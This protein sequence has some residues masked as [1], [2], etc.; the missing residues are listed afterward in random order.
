MGS[1]NETCMIS[2]MPIE[3]GDKIKMIILE[4]NTCTDRGAS[5]CY[6]T[7]FW[8][9]ASVPISCEYNDYGDFS[10]HAPDSL[11][12]QVILETLRK[13]HYPVPEGANSYHDLAV[14]HLNEWKDLWQGLEKGRLAVQDIFK[15]YRETNPD[16]LK[17]KTEHALLCKVYIREDV[18]NS[19]CESEITNYNGTLTTKVLFDQGYEYFRELAKVFREFEENKSPA[20]DKF[21]YFLRIDKSGTWRQWFSGANG[22]SEGVDHI[23]SDLSLRFENG[24]L[25]L[26]DP[27]FLKILK[28]LAE[29][30]FVKAY[31]SDIRFA[32]HPT[33]GA[34]SQESEPLTRVDFYARMM[35]VAADVHCKSVSEFDHEHS[36]AEVGQI[37]KAQE[38]MSTVSDS[39]T[40]L[41]LTEKE[42]E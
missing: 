29:L 40:R 17:R 35:K 7:D 22:C 30:A 11:D 12:C 4:E 19:I 39:L 14:P 1:W 8:G 9:P 27:E 42:F 16:P 15:S 32:W 25:A 37:N 13:R 38:C 24:T 28:A 2:G 26:H 3:P 34:G 23:I 18:W 6:S 31:T 20:E 5:G 36:K 33:I 10:E 41:I 21:R